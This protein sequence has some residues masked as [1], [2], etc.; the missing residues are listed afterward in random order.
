LGIGHLN[1]NFS[2]F[3]NEKTGSYNVDYKLGGVLGNNKNPFNKHSINFKEL[4]HLL[5]SEKLPI[6]KPR[7]FVQ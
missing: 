1:I 3:I 4:E 5:K 2:S 7:Q 6:E